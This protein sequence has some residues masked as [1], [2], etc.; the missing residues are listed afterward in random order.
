MDLT[1]EHSDSE[2]D[3]YFLSEMKAAC[4]NA[5]C[6]FQCEAIMQ[7]RVQRAIYNRDDLRVVLDIQFDRLEVWEMTWNYL[8]TF[9]PMSQIPSDAIVLPRLIIAFK[10]NINIE[11]ALSSEE[12]MLMGAEAEI[13]VKKQICVVM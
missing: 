11:E 13:F 4:L 10:N 8:N 6:R 7:Q 5:I 3:A 12:S 1:G 9:A 2:G